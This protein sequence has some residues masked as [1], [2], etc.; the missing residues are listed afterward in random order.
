MGKVIYLKD[1]IKQA[2]KEY[3]HYLRKVKTWKEWDYYRNY[4]WYLVYKRLSNEISEIWKNNEVAYVKYGKKLIQLP[5]NLR[6]DYKERC[7]IFHFAYLIDQIEH[8]IRAKFYP[9]IERKIGKFK[10]AWE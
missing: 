9:I 10:E 5:V 2:R 3:E 8:R 6:W 4:L 1:I 7:L